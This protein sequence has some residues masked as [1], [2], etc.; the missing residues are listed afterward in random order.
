MSPL[1]PGGRILLTPWTAATL[2]L[3]AL[4]LLPLATIFAGILGEPS[5]TWRHLASTVLFDY[6]WHSV[7]LVLGVGL[8]ALVLGI[9]SGWLVTTCE[10]PGRAVF[11]WSLVLPLSIPTYIMAYTYAAIFGHTGPVQALLQ[12]ALEPETTAGLRTGLMSL[13]GAAVILALALY[14]YVYLITRASFMKQS[15]GILESARILGRSP[16]RMFLGVALPVARPAIVAGVTLVLME[17]LNEYGA[18][19]YFGV[20]TFTTGIFRAW[21]SLGDAAAAIRLSGCLLLLVFALIV[22]ERI[23]RGRARFDSGPA[24][25]RPVVRF[26][27]AGWKKW[28][29][30]LA[31]GIPVL[32]GF[33]VPV[34]Q[35]VTWGLGAA[36]EVAD[37]RF[38]RLTVNSFAL[39]LVA[40]LLAVTAALVIVYSVRLAPTAVLRLAA[41]ASSLGYSIPGAVIAV[42]ILIPFVWL[43][44][45][46]APV[47]SQLSGSP[48]GLVLTGTAAALVF[49]YVVRFLAVSMNSLDAG[50]ERTCANMDESSRSLGVAPLRT[51]LRVNVPLLRGTLLAAGLL[52]FVDVLKE[53][54]LTLILRPF[55][56]DTLATRA[57][58]LA[59]DEQVA[60]SALPSLLIIAI[61]LIPVVLLTRL[62]E[63]DRGGDGEAPAGALAGVH[64]AGITRT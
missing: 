38:L 36:A 34:A 14:P 12:V 23:Q 20:T 49:A 5:D 24:P 46:L 17:V 15:G 48:A 56:F 63:G 11:A 42:G 13:P 18:V 57:F 7:V 37:P 6:A 26:Q 58:Q 39:G 9:T 44:R 25:A 43:D 3:V 54:P 51:L 31:C 33:I 64:P 1:G 50:F 40:A 32:F 52:V 41:R 4:F 8:L 19:R 53:L 35:L 59:M 28:G 29:A 27:L 16:W 22:V 21:F 30:F 60:R 61:G 47:L 45:R 10:F 55:D 2:A 62:M